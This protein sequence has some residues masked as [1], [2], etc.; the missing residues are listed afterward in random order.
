GRDVLEKFNC[1]GCHTID[2]EKWEFDYHPGK[3]ESPLPFDPAKEYAFVQPHFTPNEIEASKKVDRRGLG[4]AVVSG[5]LMQEEDDGDGNITSYF[6]PWVSV[7]IDGNI[8]RAGG[9]DV[10]IPNQAITAKHPPYGGDLARLLHPVVFEQEKKV[11]PNAKASDAWGWVPPP[12]VN[13]GQKVRAEWLYEFLVQ[14]YP[15]RPATVLRMPKFNL[16]PAESTA[17]VDYFAAKDNAQYPY[18]HDSRTWSE[19]TMS[20]AQLQASSAKL[21][22]AL[23]IVTDNNYCVKC[24]L[25]GDYVPPGSASALAPQLDRIADRLRPDYLQKWI[26]HPPSLLPYTG[27]P[28]NFPADKPANQELLKGTAEQ[29]MQAVVD[30]L[31][32]WSRLLKD[33]PSSSMKSR[34]KPPPGA[35]PAATGAG[36]E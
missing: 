4:H 23:K 33:Q 35:A 28:V 36:G 26:A 14:P 7:A 18:E 21:D 24:H 8:F 6:K 19:Y 9:Q 13:E 27:M 32:N 5:M 16:S 11:N 3:L 29:Q 31:L 2:M 17:L 10:V 25:V 20:P 12:L 30:L 15:I 22:G 34:V 1:V